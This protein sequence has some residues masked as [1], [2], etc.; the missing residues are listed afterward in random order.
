MQYT[1]LNWE[2]QVKYR[3]PELHIFIYLNKILIFKV[4]FKKIFY[5]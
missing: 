4:F 5:V 3:K 2:Q 1:D